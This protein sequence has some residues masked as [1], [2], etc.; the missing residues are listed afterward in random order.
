MGVWG[1]GRYKKT[2]H[3]GNSG[4]NCNI[5]FKVNEELNGKSNSEIVSVTGKESTNSSDG[6]GKF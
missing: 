5:Y 2:V 6:R 4:V 3:S 1:G